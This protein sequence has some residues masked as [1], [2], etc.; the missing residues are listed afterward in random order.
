MGSIEYGIDLGTTNS[1]IARWDGDSVHIFNN[2]DQMAVTPSAVHCLKSGRLVVGRRAYDALFSDPE[3]VAVEFKRQMGAAFE[4][5]FP[6]SGRT[7]SAEELS[8]AVLRSLIE[9]VQRQT[10]EIVKAAVV[11]VPTAFGVLQCEATARAAALAGLERA[12]LLQEPLAA[13]IAYGLRPGS[14]DQRFMVFD[15]GGGTL[16]ITI[17]SSRDNQL[18]MLE[19]RGRNHLGGKDVDR[20]IVENFLLPALE[21][22]YRLPTVD[23][24]P[25]GR[26]RLVRLLGRKAEEAKVDLTSSEQIQVSLFG[27][28]EDLDG[29]PIEEDVS[30]GRRQFESCLEPLIG[31]CLD[32][33][34]EAVQG[35]RI[36]AEAL[37]RIVLVGGPSQIPF[38]RRALNDTFGAL[39]DLSLDPMTAVARGAAV[40]AST[41]GDDEGPAIVTTLGIPSDK[42]TVRLEFAPVCGDLECPVTGRFDGKAAS[43]IYELRIE[44]QLGSWS[45]A[46]TSVIQGVFE[47]NVRLKAG[48]TNRF[49]ILARDSRGS[50]VQIEGGEFAIRHGVAPAASVLAKTILVELRD[51]GRV[52][53]DPLF[54]RGTPLP[55][56]RKFTYRTD[57]SL[58]PSQAGASLAI[59]L[60]E[61]DAVTDPEAN[62]W[63]G[64]VEIRSEWLDRPIP[65]GS[66]IELSISIDESR[67][68]HVDGF[69]PH[70]GGHVTH[71]LYVPDLA[72][73]DPVKEAEGLQ[74]ELGSFYE[75]L[76]AVERRLNSLADSAP[77]TEARILWG[78]TE[79]LRR[80]M[81]DLDMELGKDTSYLSDA[82]QAGRLLEGSKKVRTDLAKLEVSIGIDSIGPS[83]HDDVIKVVTEVVNEYGSDK[84]KAELDM[85]RKDYELAKASGNSRGTLKAENALKN[86]RWRVFYEQ[87]WFWTNSFE[88][89]DSGDAVFRNR[90]EAERW[91][92]VGRQTR[93]EGNADAL[94]NAV[95]R[96]W[97]LQ[98][99]HEA[100]EAREKAIPSGLRRA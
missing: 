57:R 91:L 73:R 55:A 41:L 8:A 47:V 42:T 5:T 23:E 61:G 75:R 31:E 49:R 44:D 3:N 34:K 39:C 60:W 33:A 9:D 69:V 51:A 16:D 30:I 15:F 25:E 65:E 36:S 97:N 71:D 98:K 27:V 11:T 46:W 83:D 67:L 64:L 53:L 18:T 10:G 79:L 82:D 24:D 56:S 38:V 54:E 32:L 68:I 59:K 76:D 84:H 28:G 96:L 58:R 35:A 72:Q 22:K 6:A 50:P 2:N 45:T 95:R 70:L 37:D 92:E 94:Q 14:G 17:V 99:P 26:R 74:E 43:Q 80:K 86:L 87:D 40:Y 4:K 90:R 66:I 77:V 100:E 89:L 21:A 12:P 52:T 63:I 78:K 62:T 93:V 20:L 29:E 85:V 81:E 7:L 13:A 1:C 19:H 48:A 88:Y